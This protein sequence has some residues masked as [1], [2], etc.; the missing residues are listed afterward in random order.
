MLGKL[1]E[2]DESGFSYSNVASLV[3]RTTL[4][5]QFVHVNESLLRKGVKS[6]FYYETAL[7]ILKVIQ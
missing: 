5:N 6:C 1:F 3:F 2:A 7:Y 4:V